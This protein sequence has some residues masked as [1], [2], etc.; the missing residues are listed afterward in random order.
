MLHCNIL[1]LSAELCWVHSSKRGYFLEEC[2]CDDQEGQM[3]AAHGPFDR[4]AS[5]R[6]MCVNGRINCNP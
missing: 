5:S 1:G 6:R 4:F 2:H 3:Y